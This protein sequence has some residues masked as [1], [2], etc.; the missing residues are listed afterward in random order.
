M[1]REYPA[2]QS[3]RDR[4]NN[5]GACASIGYL[6]DFSMS[7]CVLERKRNSARQLTGEKALRHGYLPHRQAH[8]HSSSQHVRAEW[9]K[10]GLLAQDLHHASH[11]PLAAAVGD[12]LE[13][14]VMNEPC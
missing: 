2:G 5:T 14:M 8:R 13:E 3:F 9:A 7:W 10:P 12:A 1:C 6:T 11:V 4:G